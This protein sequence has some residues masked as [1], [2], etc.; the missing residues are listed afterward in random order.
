MTAQNSPSAKNI[1]LDQISDFS[2]QCLNA[3]TKFNEI[4]LEYLDDNTPQ[5]IE[6]LFTHLGKAEKEIRSV[7]DF[8]NDL[9]PLYELQ[10]KLAS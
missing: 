10:T 8:T 3:F 4:S 7:N 2:S 9:K 6:D 5:F 1:L